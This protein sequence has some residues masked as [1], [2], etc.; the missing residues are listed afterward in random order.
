MRGR[1]VYFTAAPLAMPLSPCSLNENE[2]QRQC[3]PCITVCPESH[4]IIAGTA[5]RGGAKPF[6]F[7]GVFG[8]DAGQEA[9]FD[10]AVQQL[11][12]QFLAGYNATVLAYGQTG[13]CD[14]REACAYCIVACLEYHLVRSAERLGHRLWP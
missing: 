14:A 2:R 9:V 5:D 1:S 13:R 11:V 10:A 4:S 12:A 7:D 8:P 3:A 6:S